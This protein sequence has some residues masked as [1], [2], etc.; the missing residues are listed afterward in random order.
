MRYII[1]ITPTDA[2]EGAGIILAPGEAT[3]WTDE[4]T[5]ESVTIAAHGAE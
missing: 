2:D 5:G 1:T 3:V 4:T